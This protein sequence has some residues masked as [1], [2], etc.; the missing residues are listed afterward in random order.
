MIIIKLPSGEEAT[1]N[2]GVWTIPENKELA[3]VL[4]TPEMQPPENGH[5]A[6]TEDARMAHHILMVW[7]GR[8]VSTDEQF[9]PGKLY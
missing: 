6:P 8:W 9:E 4:N 5:Y 1:V 2:N 3:R 7:G